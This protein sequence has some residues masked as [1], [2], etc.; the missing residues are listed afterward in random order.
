MAFVIDGNEWAFDDWDPEDIEQAL[1]DF[2]EQL[3]RATSRGETLWFGDD[4][5][6]RLMREGRSLW[7]LFEGGLPDALPWELAQELTSY[8]GRMSCYEDEEWPESFEDCCRVAIANGDAEDNLDVLWVHLH[9]L[10]GKPLACLGLRREGLHRTCSDRGVVDMYWVR[11]NKTQ[12]AFWREAIVKEGDSPGA[13][14][15]IAPHAF[16]N[17][18]FP[19]SVWRG[20]HNFEGGYTSQ[21]QELRRYLAALDDYGA[22]IFTAPPPSEH[23]DQLQ[24]PNGTAPS[25]QLIIR[26]FTQL[27]LDIAP[28]NPN[29][30]ANRECRMARELEIGG[31]IF[32]CQWHAKLQAWQNRVHIHPPEPES[33]GKLIIA[34]MTHHLPLP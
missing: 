5:Q 32:Y 13:L 27:N 22:R 10:A 4:F 1:E 6:S 14:Q 16:P 12:V 24:K 20:C 18:Y 17:L 29:V 28:E 25:N 8:F 34:I 23:P 7:Q 9:L 15:Q 30:K 19:I 2:L 33:D 3:E 31:K 11:S 21:A 26:R